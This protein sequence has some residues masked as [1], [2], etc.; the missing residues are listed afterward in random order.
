MTSLLGILCFFFLVDNPHSPLLRHTEEERKIADERTRDNAVVRHRQIKGSQM[1]EALKEVRLWCICLAVLGLN[2]QNGALQVFSAQFIKELGDFTVKFRRFFDRCDLHQI[3]QAGESI[4]L[5][6]PAG[7]ASFLGVTAATLIA[8]RTKQLCYTGAFMCCISLAGCVIL[9]AV[10]SGP[11]KLAGFYLAWTLTGAYSLLITIIGTNV[12]GYTKKVFYN[13]AF[14]VFY[15]LGNFIGPLA[16]VEYQ[17]PRYVG[18]MTGF[19]IGNGVAF[20]CYLIMRVV[21][22]RENRDRKRNPPSE[23]TDVTLDLTDAQDRNFIYR[24]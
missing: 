24:L 12:S 21:L 18:A 4:L 10:P 3:I 20:V 8:R 1:L 14:V 9:A 5:K 6:V 23:P 11:A 2:M 19:C 16:M 7:T 17:A 13:G 22:A 15:T